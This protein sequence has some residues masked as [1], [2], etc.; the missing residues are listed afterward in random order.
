M[1]LGVNVGFV[2]ARA[3]HWRALRPVVDAIV[4]A[5]AGGLTFATVAHAVDYALPLGTR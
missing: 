2:C 1:V 3:G 4:S 5:I